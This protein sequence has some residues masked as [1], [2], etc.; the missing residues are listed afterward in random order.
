MHWTTRA[1]LVFGAVSSLMAVYYAASQHKTMGRLVRATQVR[2]WIR[3]QLPPS[4]SDWTWT[5]DFTYKTRTDPHEYRTLESDP[6]W[7]KA[8]VMKACFTPSVASVLTVSAPQVLLSLSLCC[9]IIGLGEYFGFNWT[10]GIDKEAGSIASRNVFLMFLV[11]VIVCCL[12]YTLSAFVQDGD[13]RIEKAILLESV[14]T[15]IRN[16]E[17]IVRRWNTPPSARASMISQQLVTSAPNVP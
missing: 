15:Y 8:D 10:M 17:D 5:F 12:A 11:A 2:G 7:V 14:E 3:G 13:T 9:V 4:K 16:N 1:F 6:E